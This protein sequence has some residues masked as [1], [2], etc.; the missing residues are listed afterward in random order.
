MTVAEKIKWGFEVSGVAGKLTWKELEE[1]GYYYIP[2]EDD[3][4]RHPAGMRLF[5]EDPEANPLKTPTG[6]LEFYSQRLA[7]H[8]PDDQERP[9]Y[10]K[11]IEKGPSH[12]E[13]ISSRGPRSIPCSS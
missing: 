4:E 12:D 7:D 10:P 8:F 3:W 11:W 13:R 6:K 2:T 1:K 9:P 5:Y